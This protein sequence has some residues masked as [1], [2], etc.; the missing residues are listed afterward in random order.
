MAKVNVNDSI[1]DDVKHR[2]G[3]SGEYEY[4]DRDICDA[5]NTAFAILHQLGVGPKEGFMIDGPDQ[6]YLDFT[7]NIVVIGMLRQYLVNKVE[8]YF[9][10]INSSQLIEQLNAQN[11]ELEFRMNVECDPWT[12]K[13]SDIHGT[14]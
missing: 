4:F 7:S 3:P 14:S 5:I 8:L 13:E 12:G 6:T 10:N 11:K 9:D 2:I 1:L